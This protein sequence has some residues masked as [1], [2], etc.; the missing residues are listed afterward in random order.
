MLQWIIS[1]SIVE[2][3]INN[4]PN[5]FTWIDYTY[6]YVFTFSFHSFVLRHV[7]EPFRLKRKTIS[8]WKK[9]HFSLNFSICTISNN[10]LY[11]FFFSFHSF[12]FLLNHF[13]LKEKRF[14]LERRTVSLWISI[15][16]QF[17]LKDYIYLFLFSFFRFM[18]VHVYIFFHFCC[19]YTI[20]WGWSISA[21]NGTISRLIGPMGHCWLRR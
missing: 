4:K 20:L 16:V 15:D 17:Q 2:P 5:V 8:P 18:F 13:A 3:K 6:V 9:N 12:V 10:R 21:V 19:I 11:I 7:G 1:L 14:H